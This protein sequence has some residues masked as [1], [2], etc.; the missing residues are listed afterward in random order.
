MLIL[1]KRK[2]VEHMVALAALLQTAPAEAEPPVVAARGRLRVAVYR[3]YAAAP[4]AGRGRGRR[5][6]G[7][8]AV[9]AQGA[10]IV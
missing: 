1:D 4:G 5:R 8:L 2:A 3:Q 6:A 7:K 9:A 10:P